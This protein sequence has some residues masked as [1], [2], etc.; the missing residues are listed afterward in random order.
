MA[1][2]TSLSIKITDGESPVASTPQPQI[3]IFGVLAKGSKIVLQGGIYT[4]K[5]KFILIPGGGLTLQDKSALLIQGGEYRGH[6]S[7]IGTTSLLYMSGE[8]RITDNSTL[9]MSDN[10]ISIYDVD[11]A[12]GPAWTIRLVHALRRHIWC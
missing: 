5:E 9:S 12:A 4:Y 6:F 1:T 7:V 8:V 10:R 3:Q 11:E 2:T